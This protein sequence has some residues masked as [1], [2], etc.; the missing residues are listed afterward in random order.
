[1]KKFDMTQRYVKTQKGHD[2]IKR[3]EEKLSRQARTLLV[4]LDGSRAVRFWGQVING[5]TPADMLALLERGLIRAVEE[6]VE[7]VI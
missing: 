2:E 5:S 4:I 6:E 7:S 3:K 1:M